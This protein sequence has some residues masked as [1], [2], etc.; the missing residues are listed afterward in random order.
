MLCLPACEWCLV[1]VQFS[2]V[3]HCASV[4]TARWPDEHHRPG[5]PREIRWWPHRTALLMRSLTP[6]L[7]SACAY[8]LLP[9]PAL[10]RLCGIS[11]CAAGPGVEVDTRPDLKP[12]WLSQCRHGHD[13]RSS[14]LRPRYSY[15]HVAWLPP[16]SAAFCDRALSVAASTAGSKLDRRAGTVART[17]SRHLARKLWQLICEPTKD[18]SRPRYILQPW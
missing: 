16:R 2:A 10:Q 11:I 3:S 12:Q 8:R 7:P 17:A 4:P 5:D 13:A 15:C 6:C 18:T 1:P 14:G 9:A